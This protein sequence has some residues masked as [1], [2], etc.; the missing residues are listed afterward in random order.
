MKLSTNKRTGQKVQLTSW[1]NPSDPSPGG[2]THGIESSNIPEAFTWNDSQVYWRTGPWNGQ[3]FIGVNGM[4]RYTY[5]NDGFQLLVDTQADAVSFTYSFLNL[6]R[7]FSL[8]SQGTIEGR[9]WNEGKKNW[10]VNFQSLQTECDVYG[11]CG[12]FGNCNPKKNPICSCLRGFEPKNIEEWNSGN[13]TSGC[14]RKRLLQCEKMN[15]TGDKVENDGFL[16][17]ETMKFPVFA[18]R[19]FVTIEKCRE[20]CLNNCSC[21]AYAYDAGIGCMTWTG[22]LID[23]Q[24]F[25]SGGAD[26]YIRLAHS[27]LEKKDNKVVVI[28]PVVAGTFTGAICIFFLCRWMAKHKGEVAK[29]EGFLKLEMMKVPYFAERYP[30]SVENCS[31]HCLSNC[32]C[33]AYAYDAGIGFMT[34]TRSLIDL[35]KFSDGGEADL[36]IPLAY[37]KLVTNVSAQLLDTG[38]LVLRDITTGIR[39]WESF[40]E[41]TDTFLAGMELSSHMRTGPIVQLR[42]WKSPSDPSPGSF[43]FGIGSSNIPEGFIWNDSQVY[44][45]TGPWNGLLFIG[46]PFMD[47]SYIDGYKLLADAKTGFVN[48]SYSFPNISVF[49]VLTTL[50]ILEERVWDV[51]KNDWVVS[52][53]SRETECDVY[54]WC[55]AFGN[56][57]PQESQSAAV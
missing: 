14:V 11:L 29:E 41:P 16:K 53:G 49:Y 26:L 23:L 34:W 31:E 57:N 35:Q 44:W 39:I 52:F 6:S 37:S 56:C 46:I 55:G 13:W 8:T 30:I 17:L 38:N 27:E 2:Y 3:N 21:I 18:V 22:S 33:I 12:A 40:Q 43:S 48:F 19:S 7:F 24:K 4:V 54:G 42:S 32:S 36:Y 15:Q 20:L 51:E 10:D 28:V 25:S 5:S 1:K 9:Y 45:R 47:S 50:G